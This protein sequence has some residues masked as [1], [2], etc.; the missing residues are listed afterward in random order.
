MARADSTNRVSIR[1]VAA[2][3]G[4][5]RQTVSRVINRSPLVNPE[6]RQRVESTIAKLGYYPDASARSMSRGST[7]TLACLSPN[8]TDYTFARIIEG[9][10]TE[11]RQQ[12]YF[13]LSSSAPEP[14]TFAAVA[15]Q[16]V[17]GRHA[18]GLMIINPYA[19]S[20][21]TRIPDG[22]PLVFVGARPR[23]EAADS[24]ALDDEAAARA[25]VQHLAALGHARIGMITGPLQEDCSQDRMAGYEAALCEAGL[26]V[27][28]DWMAPGDWSAT[29][30]YEAMLAMSTAR[31]QPTAVFAQNDRMAIGVM[32]AAR[33]LG[34]G[35]PGQLAVV[36]VDDMPLASYFDPPLTT[37]R[38]DLFDIGVKAAQLLVRRLREPGAP[39]VHLRL[40][41][42][43]VV[44]ES[45]AGPSRKE[46]S[47]AR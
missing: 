36:G 32:R 7:H 1:D 6:T 26:P 3:A 46:V 35:V 47:R 34:L 5:S 22:V 31:P 12:G 17:R 38:Q 30:G 10:E 44:R 8:L 41:A 37:M 2:V 42:E 45:T 20:R 25:A 40:P 21:H 11:C 33:K 43:L 13:L 4:V 19:D 16:V 27:N 39:P 15:E 24:V 18:D 28:P 14:S 29:S 9:A 23:L